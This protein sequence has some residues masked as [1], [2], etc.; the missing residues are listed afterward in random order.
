M[1]LKKIK[2]IAFDA[3]DTLWVNE[4]FFRKAEDEFCTLLEEY[5]SKEEANKL[6]FD[7]EMQNLP[8]YGYG[9][10]PFTLSLIEAAIKISNGNMT[11][12]LVQKLIEKGKEMLREPIE[13]IDGIDQTLDQLSK[14]YRLVMATKGDLLDQER[15]L[16]KS[17]LE[18]YFHHIEIVSD[19]T[20]KQYKKLVKHLDITEDEFLMVGNSLKS[21]VLPVLNIGAHAFHIPFH[22]TWVHEMVDD[23]IDHPNFRSFAKASEL[24]QIL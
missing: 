12:D 23:K 9:I 10:K 19:K 17:G 14:K 24:L 16:I 2:V 21:D 18:N 3:D 1:P 22:T 6:L 20:E 5:L 7:V 15:K 8:L 13:L 11:I 4:T